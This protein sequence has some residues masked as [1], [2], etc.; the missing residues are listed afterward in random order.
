MLPLIVDPD[1]TQPGHIEICQLGI[2]PL[3]YR[4][5]RNGNSTKEQ[6]AS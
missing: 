3:S 6:S 4:R 5:F 2:V 1:N